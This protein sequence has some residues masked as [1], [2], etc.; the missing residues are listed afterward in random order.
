MRK[1]F[2]RLSK[3]REKTQIS[4]L[5]VLR[6]SSTQIVQ[7]DAKRRI[8]WEDSA[9]RLPDEQKGNT[10]NEAKDSGIE[11]SGYGASGAPDL[12]SLIGIE[13]A[14]DHTKIVAGERVAYCKRDKVVYHDTTW[15]FLLQQNSGRCCICGKADQIVFYSLPG[16]PVQKSAYAQMPL[17]AI[18]FS[19]E[20]FIPSSEAANHLNK[21][22][23]V[24]DFV[25][26]V[27]RSKSTGTYFVRF[28]PRSLSEPPYKGFKLVIFPNYVGLWEA[29]GINIPSY[30]EKVVRVRGLIQQHKTY[31]LEIVI[32]SPYMMEVAEE[33]EE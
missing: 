13:D 25:H 28:E 18:R 3:N 17:P 9:G 7:F 33:K 32:N 21:V 15:R 8:R 1:L 11:W 23:S 27:Y 10:T 30:Q 16:E 22:V 26:E 20:T 29:L 14:F 19:N 4:I 6:R 5:N 12:H 24:Q 2:G 31:G